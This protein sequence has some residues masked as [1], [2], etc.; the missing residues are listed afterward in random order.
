MRKRSWLY[1][2][3]QQLQGDEEGA[4]PRS[5]GISQNHGG[6]DWVIMT[7]PLSP[8]KE[9]ISP[10]HPERWQVSVLLTCLSQSAEKTSS[11][12]SAIETWGERNKHFPFHPTLLFR[13]NFKWRKWQPTPVLLPGKF[14]GRRSLVGYSPCRLKEWDTT[15]QLLFLLSFPLNEGIAM[16]CFTTVQKYFGHWKTVIIQCWRAV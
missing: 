3:N 6:N 13:N 16:G 10:W 5:L 4:E 14:H 15:E 7:S 8:T 1:S 9:I 2:R 11:P 12:P